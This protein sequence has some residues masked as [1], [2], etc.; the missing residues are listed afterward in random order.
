MM[1]LVVNASNA[2]YV[3]FPLRRFLFEI[4]YISSYDFGIDKLSKRP[5]EPV[6]DSEPE[7]TLQS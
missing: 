5:F 4:S 6:A 1:V 2:F 7:D 3:P